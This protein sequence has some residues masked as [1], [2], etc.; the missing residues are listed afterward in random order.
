MAALADPLTTG[1]LLFLNAS[2]LAA[3][4]LLLAVTPAPVTFPDGHWE[5]MLLL[6]GAVILLASN[7]LAVHIASNT[8]AKARPRHRVDTAG[9]ALLALAELE[10]YH[11]AAAEGGLI[12]VVDEILGD[13]NGH[14]LA[15]V[16]SDGWFRSRRFLVPLHDLSDVDR[17]QR[18]IVVSAY[19]RPAPRNGNAG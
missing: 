10:H 7:I 18:M 1:R 3:V 8:K 14:P 19:S 12:G 11:V 15:L 13:R 2:V 5:T 4:F 17:A 6:K 9:E 16:V